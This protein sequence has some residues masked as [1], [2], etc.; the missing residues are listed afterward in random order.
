MVVHHS[1]VGEVMVEGE[2]AD[3]IT[4]LI[5]TGTAPGKVAE[6]TGLHTI[7]ATKTTFLQ[8]RHQVGYLLH[9]GWPASGMGY[10]LRRRVCLALAMGSPL[11]LQLITAEEV[12]QAAGN[13]G[14]TIL[15]LRRPHHMVEVV[16]VVVIKA[17]ET[18][19]VEIVDLKT[20]VAA[21]VVGMEEDAD[22]WIMF[23]KPRRNLIWSRA[24]MLL[25]MGCYGYVN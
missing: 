14:A 9:Q 2:V 16:A 24:Q 8:C 3:S 10:R 12:T 7:M 22:R 4:H 5:P 21:G 17:A 1:V 23:G 15:P 20:A 11:R 6:T 18:S 13:N 19:M 25:V